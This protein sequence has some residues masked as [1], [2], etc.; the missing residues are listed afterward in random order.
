MEPHLPSQSS[1][2]SDSHCSKTPYRPA[3]TSHHPDLI[4]DECTPASGGYVSDGF[5]VHIAIFTVPP[6]NRLVVG[7]RTMR[8]FVIVY[9]ARTPHRRCALRGRC[10]P[11]WWCC[12]MPGPVL[13]EK[14]VHGIGDSLFSTTAVGLQ[15]FRVGSDRMR[16]GVLGLDGALTSP[17]VHAVMTN[18]GSEHAVHLAPP[19]S[20]LDCRRSLPSIHNCRPQLN[21]SKDNILVI[22]PYRIRGLCIRKQ[23]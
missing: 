9:A 6:P 13:V 7:C 20:G 4:P 3:A 1:V 15:G 12:R 17:M 22:V 16:D 21:Q 10:V 19:V 14:R 11:E 2:R 5:V 18:R 23:L 8:G